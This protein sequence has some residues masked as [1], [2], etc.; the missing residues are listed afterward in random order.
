MWGTVPRDLE[1]LD[2]GDDGPF[3]RTEEPTACFSLVPYHPRAKAGQ[4]LSKPS[5]LLA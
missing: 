4:D 3:T 5:E 1:G 2:L